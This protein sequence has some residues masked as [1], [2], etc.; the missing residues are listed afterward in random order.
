MEPCSILRALGTNKWID[1][2]KEYEKEKPRAEILGYKLLDDT[3]STKYYQVPPLLTKS[4]RYTNLLSP[5]AAFPPR[6]GVNMT[7]VYI[8]QA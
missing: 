3:T 1:Q 2:I 7:G 8:L 6:R 4:A 5:P